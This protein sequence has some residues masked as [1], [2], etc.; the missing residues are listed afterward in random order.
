LELEPALRELIKT[1]IRDHSARRIALRA[2]LASDPLD[3][4]WNGS[5]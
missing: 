1:F 4:W 5:I 3:D 2:R